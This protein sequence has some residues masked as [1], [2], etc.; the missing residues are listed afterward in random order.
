MYQFSA[1]LHLMAAVVWL[2]GL[3]F[4]A[5]VLVPIA[6]G[7]TE[8]PGVAAR[9]LSV[10]ARRFRII[11]W[12]ALLVLVGTGVWNLLARGVSPLEVFTG[13]GWFIQTLRVKGALVTAVLALSALH[14]F[15]VGPRLARRLE[16]LRGPPAADSSIARRRRVVS[17]LARLNMLLALAIAALGALLVRGIP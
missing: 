4:I 7:T 10:A 12:A 8:P 1:Y 9:L 14:D 17:W 5:M 3:L 6:R 13:G 11:G 15:L 2:G 16:A